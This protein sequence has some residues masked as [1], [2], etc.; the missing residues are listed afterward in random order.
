[1]E[2]IALRPVAEDVDELVDEPDVVV[3]E[4]R[5]DAGERYGVR[6]GRS[7]GG[8]G[9]LVGG[10]LRV[11]ERNGVGASDRGGVSLE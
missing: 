1:M 9:D 7:G 6:G 5:E 8:G 3:R 4:V 2:D 10:D 11:E